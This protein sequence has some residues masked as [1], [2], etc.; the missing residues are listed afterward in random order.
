MGRL[1]GSLSVLLVL[2]LIYV[3]TGGDQP[4]RQ[5]NTSGY[6]RSQR[7]PRDS[8]AG[9]AE[10]RN[11]ASDP[12]AQVMRV[13]KTQPE[14][15]TRLLAAFA[16]WQEDQPELAGKLMMLVSERLC[17]TPNVSNPSGN[18]S[19]AELRQGIGLILN[20][21]KTDEMLPLFSELA[22][23]LST[24]NPIEAMASLK[25]FPGTLPEKDQILGEM[26]GSW[27]LADPHGATA[28]A[29]SEPS[30]IARE[31]ML[32]RIVQSLV[33]VNPAGA[34]AIVAKDFE[35][36]EAEANS[37]RTVVGRWA[38]TNPSATADWLSHFPASDLRKEMLQV[39]IPTWASQHQ[40]ALRSWITA[41]PPDEFRSEVESLSRHLDH[42]VLS[43]S[44][45]PAR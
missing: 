6:T 28:W 23:R 13:L 3:I 1:V 11:V 35:S 2:L 31:T 30:G 38:W 16:T 21:E 43:Q 27:V 40:A 18:W 29:C 37:A 14:R 44:V 20:L 45:V 26:V 22:A 32:Q 19:E 15:Q 24:T 9:I 5:I 25:I 42:A 10:R 7:E 12:L 4:D 34:A 17:G 33:Q 39:M 36:A 41:L 8:P